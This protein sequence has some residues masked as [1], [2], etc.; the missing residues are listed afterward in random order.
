MFGIVT[1][2]YYN[3]KVTTMFDDFIFAF[4]FDG[5]LVRKTKFISIEE[6]DK[7]FETFKFFINPNAFSLN[8]TIVTS[9]PEVDLEKLKD[10]CIRNQ[11]LP[12]YDI[13]CQF[14]KSIPEVKN[15]LEYEIKANHLIELGNIYN[16]RMVYIDNDSNV[17]NMVAKSCKEIK[18]DND[19]LF[20]DMITMFSYFCKESLKKGII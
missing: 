3:R 17:R 5:T 20:K 13:R 15:H 16:K 8:W 4:D 12:T 14:G 2:N 7:N 6:N 9:R 10:C 18:P 19:I 1:R 11:A